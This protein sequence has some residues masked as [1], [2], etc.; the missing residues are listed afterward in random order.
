[1]CI[2]CVHILCTSLWCS[3][4]NSSLILRKILCSKQN[5][6]LSIPNVLY[7]NKTVCLNETWGNLHSR[8][9][10]WNTDVF[11]WHFQIC[12]LGLHPTTSHSVLLSSF[13]LC[14]KTKITF[15]VHKIIF[16]FFFWFY[17]WMEEHDSRQEQLCCKSIENS[18]KLLISAVYPYTGENS[19][20]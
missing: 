1:M 6:S 8:R 20:E 3:Y 15:N 5:S 18:R 17:I 16:I 2:T 10:L 4:E 11:I 14:D 13:F 12:C 9:L 7:G 19:D